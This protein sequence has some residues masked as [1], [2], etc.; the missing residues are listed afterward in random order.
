MDSSDTVRAVDLP[1][2]QGTC[3]FCGRVNDSRRRMVAGPAHYI[4]EDCV[5][6][7]VQALAQG[8]DVHGCLH[9]LKPGEPFFA[10]RAQDK[11]AP[12]LVAHWAELALLH[13]CG[14]DKVEQAGDVAVRM[15]VWANEHAA[16]WPD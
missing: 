9:R 12:A 6:A 7:A 2:R 15:Q 14:Q 13:G 16:K 5:R 10:L 1:P 4:C 3:A 8:H 11:L